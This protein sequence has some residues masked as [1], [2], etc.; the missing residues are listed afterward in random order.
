MGDG[1]QFHLHALSSMY[2][3]RDRSTVPLN[4]SNSVLIGDALSRFEI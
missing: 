1:A 2:R 3:W 4:R